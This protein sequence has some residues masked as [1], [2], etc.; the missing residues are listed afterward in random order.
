VLNG[1]E[2]SG[3]SIRIHDRE[4]QERVFEILGMSR[5]R[6][7]EQFGH[8]LD[9]FEYGVPPH[10]GIAAGIDRLMMAITGTENV[11]DVVAFPKT[12]SHQDLMLG[13]PS[14]VDPKQLEELHIRVVQ[15]KRG[16][17]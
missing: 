10:G 16:P 17:S 3:G 11:R 15:P 5:E 12:Q 6:I 2:I 1:V 8:L 4:L 9:A 14:P 13:A 7:R